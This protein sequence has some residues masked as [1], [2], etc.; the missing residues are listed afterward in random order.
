MKFLVIGNGIVALSTAFRLL[1][2]VSSNDEVVVIGPKERVGSAT[3][4]AAAMQNSFAEVN[5]ESFKTDEDF[6]HFELSHEATRLWPKFER[7]LIDMAGDNLPSD[8]RQCE[9]FNG[10][11]FDR[12]TYV[13]NNTAADELDDRNFNAIVSALNEFNEQHEIVDPKE[14]PNYFPSQEKRAT[15][16]VYIHNEGWLNPALVL[17]KLDNILQNDSRVTVIDG[18][19]EQL[20]LGTD[21]NAVVKMNDGQVFESDEILLAAGAST[22]KIL[23]NSCLPI[24]TVKMFYG[25]GVSLEIFSPGYPHTKCIRT[26]NRGG[27]CGMYSV[28]LYLGPD[29]SNEHIVIGASNYLS[30]EPV[31]N[32]RLVSIEHLMKSAVEEINGNF[33]NAQLVRT[34]V[35]WRPTSQ[36]TYPLIG[37]TSIKNLTVAS[38][39]KRDGFHLS[40]VISRDICKILL[41]QEVD[42]RYELFHPERQLIKNIPRQSGIEYIVDSLMSEQYQHGYKPSNIRMNEQVRR[43]YKSEIETLHDEVGAV[44]WAIHPELVNMYRRGFAKVN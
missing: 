11:C 29:K 27:A 36:D 38:G 44:D 24:E 14:I 7:E 34:N 19:V 22:Q 20:I 30:P 13:L 40:P 37:K 17:E 12:G 1:Q 2:Q 6:F 31:Y 21:G 25:V 43:N 18:Y 42:E 32:G 9:I 39:T 16:A 4:A 3:L 23:E 35:G 33:Y 5:S 10:G 26:P 15:K 28:P 8:C 41:N